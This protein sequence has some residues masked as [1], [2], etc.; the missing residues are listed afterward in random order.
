MACRGLK[1][2]IPGRHT[3]PTEL[4]KELQLQLDDLKTIA[5]DTDF[6]DKDDVRIFSENIMYIK[7][8]FETYSRL[9]SKD[10]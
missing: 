3:N 8:Y 10:E 5:L 4:L 6:D 2:L 9:I 7:R 1:S